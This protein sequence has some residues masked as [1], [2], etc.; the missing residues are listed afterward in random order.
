MLDELIQT[1]FCFLSEVIAFRLG[2]FYL[3]ILTLGRF[4]PEL[5][6][7]SQPLV[8]FFGA[9]ITLAIIIFIAI[10]INNP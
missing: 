4:K 6:D 5:N 8:S 7:T 1:T 3:R 10:Q 2:R 9:L